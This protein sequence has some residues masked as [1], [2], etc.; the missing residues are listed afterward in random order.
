M[1]LGLLTTALE[2]AGKSDIAKNLTGK[3][4]EAAIGYFSEKLGIPPGAPEFD[5]AAADHVR[6]MREQDFAHLEKII[7]DVQHARNTVYGA[8][9]KLSVA[10]Q[11]WADRM[12]LYESL[13]MSIGGII[14]VIICLVVI[15]I[16]EAIYEIEFSD[17]YKTL[18]TM[19]ITFLTRELIAAR[20]QYKH[21]TTESSAKK[22]DQMN[23]VIER[24]Q[25]EDAQSSQ[26]QQRY[27]AQL[28]ED[29]MAAAPQ[30]VVSTPPPADDLFA[31]DLEAADGEDKSLDQ[32]LSENRQ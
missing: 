1:A 29:R 30:A 20:S 21:G 9:G 19:V 13:F 28:S 11:E 32:L 24:E 4:G 17:F 26:M 14:I 5:Q 15:G 23:Q 18:V 8:R 22:T 12:N 3:A 2:L 31:P 10:H 27:V 16:M 7:A 25:R 6:A